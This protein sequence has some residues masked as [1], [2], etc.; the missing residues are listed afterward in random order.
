LPGIQTGW[1][2]PSFHMTAEW[3]HQ[4]QTTALS[5]CGMLWIR[6]KF[7]LLWTT[8]AWFLGSVFILMEVASHLAEQTKKSKFSMCARSIFFNTT[9]R[10]MTLWTQ[11]TSIQMVNTSSLAQTTP[12]SKYGTW[13]RGRSCTQSS[14]TKA[15]PRPPLFPHLVTSCSQ[16][17]R[18]KT[19]WSGIQTWTRCALKSFMGLLLPACQQTIL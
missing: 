17:A 9:M 14:A 4:A 11:L 8:R 1:E 18:T 15:P 19:L 7:T 5:N 16:E 12:Q 3:L 2:A 6:Q 13:G 10:I